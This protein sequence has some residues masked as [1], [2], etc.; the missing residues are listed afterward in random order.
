MGTGQIGAGGCLVWG[1]KGAIILDLCRKAFQS[2]WTNRLYPGRA[3]PRARAPVP[4]PDPAGGY[5]GAH[6]ASALPH[7]EGAPRPGDG[8]TQPLAAGRVRQGHT[9]NEHRA[10]PGRVAAA[11][12]R[13]PLSPRAPAQRI[14]AGDR[15]VE[16][17][18]TTSQRP[19]AKGQVGRSVLCL[20]PI[21]TVSLC[22]TD[23]N[24]LLNGRMRAA[25]VTSNTL[26]SCVALH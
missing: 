23:R 9:H 15:R 26:S 19:V 13:D 3:G 11:G 5:A 8:D 16:A 18:L 21:E 10:L 12:R 25:F 7:S 6:A 2:W 4:R 22:L 14:G 24:K 17:E 20:A 1:R